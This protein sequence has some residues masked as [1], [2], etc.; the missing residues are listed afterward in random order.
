MFLSFRGPDTR[1]RFTDILFHSLT[2]AGICIFQDN[3]ELRVRER[4]DGSLQQAINYS[5][6]YILVFSRTYASSQWCLH[7]LV[8]IVA[9]TFKLEGNKEILPIFFNVEP[10]DIKLKT[11]LYRDVILNLERKKKLS[12][13][14]A[15]ACR[16]ALVE[17][18]AIKGWEGKKYKG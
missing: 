4:I 16:E 7:E 3:E 10:D 13:E 17:V 18:D 15:D 5:R 9:N 1:T 6:I 12:N 8:Q 14:Q 11:P 2:G